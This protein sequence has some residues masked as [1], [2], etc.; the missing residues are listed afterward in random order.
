MD[1]RVGMPSFIDKTLG[2][3]SAYISEAV[4]SEK[5]SGKKGFLQGID[6]RTKLVSTIAFVLLVTT[7]QRIETMLFFLFVA[8][9]L[10]FASRIPMRFFAVRVLFFVP[11]FTGIIVIPAVFNMV[12]PGQ[13]V[14]RLFSF[15]EWNLS[16]TI[17]GIHAAI[18]LIVRTTVAVSFP[19]LLTLTTR[20]N[21]VMNAM[22]SLKMPGIFILILAMT[23]RY[24]FLFLGVLDKMLLSRKSRATG[25]LKAI[26]ACKLYAP[27]VGAIFTKAYDLNEKVFLAMLA[28][29]FNGEV[30]SLK[31][32][33]LSPASLA[34]LAVTVSVCLVIILTELL[35][36]VIK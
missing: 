32:Q 28:R 5:F 17:E 8:G 25:K 23:Y 27:I 26:T 7:T 15:S 1:A 30:K 24:I 34:F 6:A 14:L 29:G 35:F 21:E 16:I 36:S 22:R 10:A 13:E 3:I 4:Y 2:Q 18:I 20:W 33:K 31:P 19:V 11:L 9:A 12:T